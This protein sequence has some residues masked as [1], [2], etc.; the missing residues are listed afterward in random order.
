MTASVPAARQGVLDG[1]R[2]AHTK[3][4]RSDI[5]LRA[6]GL[7]ASI[8]QRDVSTATTPPG[9]TICRLLTMKWLCIFN[10][11]GL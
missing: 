9:R 2:T 11:A 6:A 4:A 8:V 3:S 7:V 10:R 1:N 5:A